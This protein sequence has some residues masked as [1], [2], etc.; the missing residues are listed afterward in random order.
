MTAL[1]ELLLFNLVTSLMASPMADSNEALRQIGIGLL[2]EGATR[3]CR[4]RFLRFAAIGGSAAWP[5]AGEDGRLA[6]G[7]ACK[8]R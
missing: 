1:P 5:F 4:Y 2:G 7:D 6:G 3:I 8:H